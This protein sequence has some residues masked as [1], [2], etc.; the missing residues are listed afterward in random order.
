MTAS[1][2][3]YG[4]RS[5]ARAGPRPGGGTGSAGVGA[6]R[7]CKGSCLPCGYPFFRIHCSPL[8]AEHSCSNLPAIY[9]RVSDTGLLTLYSGR[10]RGEGS[11]NRPDGQEWRRP[12]AHRRIGNRISLQQHGSVQKYD[13][14][15]LYAAVFPGHYRHSSPLSCVAG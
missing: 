7:R 8:F 11:R 10:R 13:G 6:S 15:A 14:S 4:A 5:P 1:V 9:E 12:S 3:C 2:G